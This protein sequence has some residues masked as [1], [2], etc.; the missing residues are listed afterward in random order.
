MLSHLQF[1]L[2][3]E[4]SALNA[5]LLCAMNLVLQKLKDTYKPF[6]GVYV[7]ANGDRL[8]LPNV[9]EGDIFMSSS[10]LYGFNFHFLQHLVRMEDVAGRRL[11]KLMEQRPIPENDIEE[12]DALFAT[13]CN[14]VSDWNDVDDP[15]VMKVFGKKSAERKALL[16]HFYFIESSG[17]PHFFV[18]AQDEVKIAG[19]HSWRPCSP[20]ITK[21]LNGKCRESQRILVYDRAIVSVTTNFDDLPQGSLGV[22][23]YASS[24]HRS[25]TIY[26]AP[27]PAA[28]TEESIS[29]NLYLTWRTKAMTI[30]TGYK[31]QYKG[32][33]AR[34]T[35]L[36]LLNYVAAN[37]H[38]LLGDEFPRIATAITESKYALW[39]PAQVFV[40]GS[41]VSALNC[42]TFMGHNRTH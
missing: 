32:N 6:G 28:F 10:L 18:D 41:R 30:H 9:S 8:Q 3:E 1:L 39:L 31:I 27:F 25:V 42:I 24:S 17:M 4:V 38:R 21:Y 35:Q 14:F 19:S 26:V 20:I 12:I 2:G 11:L 37:C 22:I 23:H 5:E 33:S 7:L 40:I 15:S 36:P 34:R 29:S 16:R 13:H